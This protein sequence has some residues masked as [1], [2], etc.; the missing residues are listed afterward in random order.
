MEQIRQPKR[1]LRNRVRFLQL[2]RVLVERSERCRSHHFGTTPVSFEN[3]GNKK[4]H[5]NL[6]MSGETTHTSSEN[7]PVPNENCELSWTDIRFSLDLAGEAAFLA[8][9]DREAPNL[10]ESVASKTQCA[11][12]KRTGSQCKPIYRTRRSFHHLMFTVCGTAICCHR[13]A[14]ENTALYGLGKWS[15]TTFLHRRSCNCV[16][17]VRCLLGKGTTLVS[18]TATQQL[19]LASRR[20]AQNLCISLNRRLPDNKISISMCPCHTI[21]RPG[22]WLPGWTGTSVSCIWNGAIWNVFWP[23]AMTLTLFGMHIR[24]TLW[25]M[26]PTRWVCLEK[27]GSMTTLSTTVAPAQGYFKAKRLHTVFGT[28]IFLAMGFIAEAECIEVTLR[29]HL[30]MSRSQ[31]TLTWTM[32][33]LRWPEFCYTAFHCKGI[34]SNWNFSAARTS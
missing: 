9:I 30:L 1:A 28:G 20:I 13:S 26:R 31:L 12:T 10:Y 24:F 17:D 7:L 15:I 19:S 8:M 33:A 29:P 32:W 11:A 3:T 27:Y 16:R 4:D 22:F 34:I 6:R 14:T 23:P 18:L 21:G 25:C 5:P 2:W